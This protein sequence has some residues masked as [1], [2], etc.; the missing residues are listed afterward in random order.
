MM[1][2][3]LSK[4]NDVI[5]PTKM[6]EMYLSPAGCSW[7][8]VTGNTCMTASAPQ[9]CAEHLLVCGE[10]GRREDSGRYPPSDKAGK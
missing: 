3:Y 10:E 4:M 2:T 6:K 9:R 5:L 8:V 1:H 7:A